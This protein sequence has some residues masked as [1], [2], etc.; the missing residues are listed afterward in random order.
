M[1]DHKV[2][3]AELAF[4]NQA[5]ATAAP[6]PPSAAATPAGTSIE[7]QV[8]AIKAEIAAGT[9]TRAAQLVTLT[10]QAT[11]TAAQPA[12]AA[13]RAQLAPATKSPSKAP[14]IARAPD[15]ALDKNKWHVLITVSKGFDDMLLNWW[16]YFQKLNLDI[17]V[18][19]VAEDQ[20]TYDAYK[21][22]A[23]WNVKKGV[24]SSISTAA[25]SYDTPHYK[26]L[27][28]RRA[29]YI[30]TYLDVAPKLIYSDIDTVRVSTGHFF[31]S[32][33]QMTLFVYEHR[34]HSH[35]VGVAER[36]SH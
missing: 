7:S 16:Y 23:K 10:Q 20:P 14:A 31:P 5:D 15:S 35:I 33:T 3:W 17:G 27:V 30:D 26:K 24:F 13:T 8:A 22:F 34:T 19:V 12:I 2:I 9:F 21:G 32:C 36:P 18:I 4:S 1:S 28:S 29:A 25:L 11:A 6:K